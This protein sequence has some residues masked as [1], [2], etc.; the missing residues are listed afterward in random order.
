MNDSSICEVNR[1]NVERTLHVSDENADDWSEDEVLKQGRDERE[2]HAE[3]G[4]QEV[5][6]AQIHQHHIGQSPHP[7]VLCDGQSD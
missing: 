4:Q 3:C 5:G 2:R 7:A 1:L 6:D